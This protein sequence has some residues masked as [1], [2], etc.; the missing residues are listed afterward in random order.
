MNDAR[1]A[2]TARRAAE[3]RADANADADVLQRPPV[4][5][6]V[7]LRRQVSG[8]LLRGIVL[9]VMTAAG[10]SLAYGAYSMSPYT[11]AALPMLSKAIIAHAVLS[12]VYAWQVRSGSRYIPLAVTGVAGVFLL[13]YLWQVYVGANKFAPTGDLIPLSPPPAST[14]PTH[15]V[16]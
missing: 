14:L 10:L 7:A 12:A 13:A 1:R 4:D 6:A 15:R 11:Q 2:R 8:M 9:A 16:S 5:P 3:R